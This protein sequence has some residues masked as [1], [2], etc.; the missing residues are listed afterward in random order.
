MS[1]TLPSAQVTVRK[2]GLGVATG[3]PTNVHVA[4]GPSSKG[5]MKQPIAFNVSTDAA[6]TYGCG[7]MPKAAA[8]GTR[9]RAARYVAIR[10]PAVVETA[11]VSTITKPTGKTVTTTGTP[12]WGYDV[13][14]VFSTGGTIG[15]IGAF[16]KVSL[17]GGVTFTAPVAL[18]TATSVL[19]TGTGVTIVLTATEVWATNDEIR[20]YTRPASQAISPVTT[21]R[22]GTS[23]CVI[24]MTGTPEDEYEI[25]FRALT[26]GTI[27]TPGITYDYS[28]DGGETFST[29]AQLGTATSVALLDGTEASGVTVNLA[30]G[31]LDTLDKAAAKTTGPA[32]QASDALEALDALRASSHTWRFIHLAGDTTP[33]K[34]S[35]VGGKMTALEG[36]GVFTYA[37]MSARD[38]IDGEVDALGMPSVAWAERLIVDYQSFASDRSS[39]SAGR[40]RVTCPITGRSNRRPASWVAC[41]RLIENT[42][43][44]DPG[45]K[46]DGP[47]SEDV[48]IFDSTGRLAELNSNIRSALHSARFLTL[49]TY[50]REAGTYITR[51]NSMAAAGSE[52]NRIAMRAVMD[53]ASEVYQ[54]VMLQQIENNLLAN[55]LTGAQPGVTSGESLVPGALAE[56]DARIIDRELLT[57]LRAVLVANGYVSAVRAQV[58]RTDPFLTTGI[59]TAKVS[60][61]PLGYVDE[62]KGDIFFESPRLAAL[63]A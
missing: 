26:G 3:G 9:R 63:I 30:A 52:F 62:F 27:G 56:A 29:P 57:A 61:T 16:W 32:W 48:R 36:L 28:L 22:V 55:P 4:I 35:S 14:F 37:L 11:T 8:Y 7:P 12:N 25:V 34:A 24:T 20:F 53:L 54:A 23:T 6:G 59:L 33:A 40:A 5:P 31:T 1:L 18:G 42:I 19:L 41:A 13:V 50:D 15:T 21:T 47:L 10:I 38:R 2:G 43:Q 17:D 46:L 60:L 44:V 58:S 39:V 45:R 49:R 51:G